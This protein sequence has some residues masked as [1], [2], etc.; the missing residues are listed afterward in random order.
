MKE[1]RQKVKRIVG[2]HHLMLLLICLAALFLALEFSGNLDP[3]IKYNRSD[4]VLNVLSDKLEASIEIAGSIT[5]AAIEQSKRGEGNAVFG[6]SRGV[7]AGMV[8]SMVSG[9][10]A[11]MIS[12]SVKNIATSV[13][14]ALAL[15]A[16]VILFPLADISTFKPGV[17]ERKLDYQRHYPALSLVVIFFVFS[18]AGWVW[19]VG[20]HLVTSGEFVNRGVLHGPWLPIYGTG[21]VLILVALNIFRKKPVVE[22]FSVVVLCGCVEYFTSC[23]LEVMHG[24]QKWWD[25]SG[26]FLNLNGRIC[27]EGLLAFGLGGMALVYLLAPLLDNCLRRLNHRAAILLC[28][29]LLVLF[30]A[31]I[32]YSAKYPNAGEGI[33]GYGEAAVDY[34]IKEVFL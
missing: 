8:N 19:E 11:Y 33:T 9:S 23:C 14:T 29:V 31:D 16:A 21:S 18:A 26:Y 15:M 5:R 27:A 25:Y 13:R 22:F 12:C 30:I 32:T 3:M 10:V 24:G 17:L 6:R 4:N 1:I 20:L 7:F 34:G 28:A 2:G